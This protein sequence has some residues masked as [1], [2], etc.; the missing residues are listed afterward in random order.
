MPFFEPSLRRRIFHKPRKEALGTIPDAALQIANNRLPMSAQ[1]KSSD[2]V[3]SLV[4]AHAVSRLLVQDQDTLSLL[5]IYD[6]VE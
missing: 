5:V 4:A 2:W 6:D 3:P 1:L